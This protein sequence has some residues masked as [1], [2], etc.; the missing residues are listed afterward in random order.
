MRWGDENASDEEIIEA[1]KLAQADEFIEK[2][3][4]NMI[5]SLNKVVLTFLGGN[6]KDYVLLGR[7]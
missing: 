5:L 2:M 1:C 7:Y 6:D 4:I 3:R